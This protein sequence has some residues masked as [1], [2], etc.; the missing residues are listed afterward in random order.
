MFDFLMDYVMP[1]FLIIL[2][3]FVV[4]LMVWVTPEII[5]DMTNKSNCELVEKV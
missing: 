5:N 1:A 4:L 2:V 3:A